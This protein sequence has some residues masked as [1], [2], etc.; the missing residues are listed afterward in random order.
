MSMQSKDPDPRGL[1][2]VARWLYWP[3]PNGGTACG[4]LAGPVVGVWSHW[5]GR[6]KPCRRLTSD[7]AL[8]CALC[9]DGEDPV[10]RGYLPVYDPQYVRR[11]VVITADH[12]ES[13]REIPLHAQVKMKRGKNKHDPC[14]V[15]ADLWRTTPLPDS[16]DRSAPADIVP[17]LLRMWR[18][19]ELI[20]WHMSS[21]IPVSSSPDAGPVNRL[22]AIV[23][24]MGG[25][26]A[27]LDTRSAAD[28]LA[29]AGIDVGQG[30]ASDAPPKP[31]KNGKPHK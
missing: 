30:G 20:Q 22:D 7:G 3:I 26:N 1:G 11:I 4:F 10:W 27:K 29:A 18:D 12:A 19:V 16:P 15:T 5:V 23:K 9:S 8:S 6:S 24:P 21:D 14:V 17:A 13:V 25:A 31:S 2:R 28:I